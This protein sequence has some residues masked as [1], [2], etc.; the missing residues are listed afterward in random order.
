MR[1]K[2]EKDDSS[3]P[4]SAKQ[5]LVRVRLL[6]MGYLRSQIVDEGITRHFIRKLDG[7]M[8]SEAPIGGEKV[9]PSF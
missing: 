6:E 3:G 1:I 4:M 8:R 2:A 5:K 7:A 9:F